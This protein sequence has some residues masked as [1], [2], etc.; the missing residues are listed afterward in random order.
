MSLLWVGRSKVGKYLDKNHAQMD[1]RRRSAGL[2]YVQ[3]QLVQSN[4]KLHFLSPTIYL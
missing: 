1:L 2:E 3:D 4:F